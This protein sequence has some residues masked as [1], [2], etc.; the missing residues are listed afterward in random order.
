LTA[1][2]KLRR[3]CSECY[4]WD[5]VGEQIAQ[6]DELLD[7]IAAAQA[8]GEQIDELVGTGLEALEAIAAYLTRRRLPI[9]ELERIEG[10]LKRV[11]LAAI[12]RS[13]SGPAARKI[14][15]AQRRLGPLL[16]YKSY[17]IKASSPLGYSVF[18]Q[19]PGEGF[20]FQ[21]HV[22]HK[23]EIF[24]ILAPLAG[25]R[26]FMCGHSDWLA[27]FDERRFR[28]WLAGGADPEFEAFSYVPSAGD[29]LVIDRLNVVHTVIGCILEEFATVS[30]DMV[31]RLFDQ[32]VG[33]TI[34]AVEPQRVVQIESG[35]FRSQ[36]V[37]AE[38]APWGEIREIR[39][40]ALIARH[41]LIHP[42]RK[43]QTLFD[44]HD[45]CALFVRAGRGTVSI[46]DEHEAKAG[47][48]PT[49]EV[50]PGDFLTIPAAVNWRA[51]SLSGVPLRISSQQLPVD[52][53]LSKN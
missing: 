50:T 25:A 44:P 39:A 52:V 46:Y 47:N 37:V 3:G 8:A 4:G 43:T 36:P 51:E 20:S 12:P 10:V 49:I 6:M 9:V 16:K 11:L 22:E 27:R 38:R 30:T 29:V 42:G 13:S 21:R 45:S 35:T 48:A 53:A 17:A 2:Q 26:A 40:G 34:P 23:V 15:E 33:Q 18:L 5:R 31:D 28:A 24:H 41:L 14:A 7:R 19:K 1:Q 32:N